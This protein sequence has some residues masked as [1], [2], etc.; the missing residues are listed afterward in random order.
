[1]VVAAVV[2]A[3]VYLTACALTVDG[4]LFASF[5]FQIFFNFFHYL[6]C[7]NLLKRCHICFCSPC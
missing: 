2:M 4:N 3:V 7:Y 1:M 6:V 5:L